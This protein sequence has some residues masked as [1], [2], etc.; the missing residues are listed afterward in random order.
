MDLFDIQREGY[1]IKLFDESIWA[2]KGCCLLSNGLV[3]IPR[4]ISGVKIKR[5]REAMRIV[6]ERYRN[7]LMK[8]SFSIEEIPVIPISDVILVYRPSKYS[9]STT[10][11]RIR[12]VALDLLRILGD[13]GVDAYIT[14]SLLY[15]GADESSD[16]D[17]V[18]YSDNGYMDLR[19]AIEN[20]FKE[21]IFS[22]LSIDEKKHVI[23]RV[24]E[25]IDPFSH[26]LL[27]NRSIHEFIFKGYMV[28]MRYVKCDKYIK[29]LICSSIKKYD[30][31]KNSLL[32]IDDSRGIYTPS[33]YLSRD[34][35]G[36][37]ILLYSHR[38]RYA[39]LRSGDV[40]RCRG[41]IE[42]LNNDLKRFNLDRA[43]CFIERL[44]E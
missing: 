20:L 32:V 25:G 39:N 16:I 29:D 8:T 23:E 22:R 30:F 19:E 9:C 6:S 28:S 15:C 44:S 36:E 33:L 26:S 37:E 42:Y 24:S 41:Y 5:L 3:A 11:E 13:S 14:G 21:K 2:V 40:I 35:S 4:V 31:Y 12:N 17:A 27:L 38:I 34:A 7:F 1:Y 10:P 18:V 43:E